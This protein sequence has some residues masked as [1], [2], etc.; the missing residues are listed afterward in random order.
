MLECKSKKKNEKE[1]SILTRQE[2]LFKDKLKA[3]QSS[4]KK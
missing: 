1:Q 4:I 2:S 3:L